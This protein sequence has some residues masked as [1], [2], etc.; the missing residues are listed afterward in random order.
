MRDE[1]E[2]VEAVRWC[3]DNRIRIYPVI[4]P[5]PSEMPRAKTAAQ[6]KDPNYFTPAGYKSKDKVRICV[7]VGSKKKVGEMVF[8]QNDKL[9]QKIEDLYMHY[10][11][12]RAV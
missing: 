1:L 12:K 9:Y 7:E 8:D 6:R 4:H 2:V 11:S 5:L 10:Y 3:W